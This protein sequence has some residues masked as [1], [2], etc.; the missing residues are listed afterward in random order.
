MCK[1]GSF[2]LGFSS[3]LSIGSPWTLLSSLR[4]SPSLWSPDHFPLP[5][6]LFCFQ[7]HVLLL[8]CSYS[9]PHNISSYLLLSSFI[10]FKAVLNGLNKI[11]KHKKSRL[12]RRK[13]E[14]NL[15]TQI[16]IC[17]FHPG[18]PTENPLELIQESSKII[19]CKVG[20]RLISVVS[21]T[22][23]NLQKT[24]LLVRLWV[25]FWMG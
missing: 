14:N 10:P 12:V 13:K 7:T 22:R 16:T 4:P 23:Q 6:V 3:M 11:G 2:I 19:N 1:E 18:Q 15:C 17:V 8:F 24:S 20:A 21:L 5:S 9:L 25:S